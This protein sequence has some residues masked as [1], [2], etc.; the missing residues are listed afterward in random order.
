MIYLDYAAATPVDKQVFEV[1]KKY[2]LEHFGNPSSFY[3]FAQLSK[4]AVDNSRDIIAKALNAPFKEIFFNSGGTEGNNLAI[5]GMFGEK[6]FHNKHIVTSLIE[7][8]AVLFPIQK[9]KK[10][11]VRV[12]Y[13]APEKNGIVNPEK[14][15]AALRPETALV[16]IM[17]ANNEIGTIQPIQEIGAIVKEY[18]KSQKQ[19]LAFHTDACQAAPYLSLDVKKLGVDMLTLSGGKIYGPKGVGVL[20]KKELVNLSP[21]ILGGGQEMGLRSGTENVPLIVGM[22]EAL[23]LIEKE[24]RQESGRLTELRDFFIENIIKKI[25]ETYINGDRVFRLPNNIHLSFRGVEGAELLLRLDVRGV[26]VSLGSACTT[27]SVETSHV[28]KAISVPAGLAQGGLRITMGKGTT[29]N[30][31]EKCIEILQEEVAQVRENSAFYK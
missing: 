9:L 28:L 18:K 2:F 11:G 31:I 16:S 3:S 1:M 25:P 7:H 26:F 4:Q 5:S 6:S 22:A 29:K 24:K 15:L 12:T 30:D 19:Q 20:Y 23:R 13:V 21:Q 8:H 10:N 17:Y 14:V 27:G